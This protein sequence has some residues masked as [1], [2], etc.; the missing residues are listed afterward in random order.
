MIDK[1]PEWISIKFFIL[2]TNKAIITQAAA[3]GDKIVFN[4]LKSCVYV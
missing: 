1:V 4:V 3:V 2:A